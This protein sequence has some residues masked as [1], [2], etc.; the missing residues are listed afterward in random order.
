[1]GS[2][3]VYILGAVALVLAQTAL[4]VGLLLQ[5]ARRRHAEDMM[6]RS[7]AELR[8]SYDRIRDLGVRLMSAQEAERARI[9]RELHD[10]VSQQMALLAI[11]LG[12]LSGDSRMRQS[13]SSKLAHDAL[14][15]A[16]SVARSVHD[17]SHRLH[18]ANLRMLGLVEALVS[19][20]HEFA[21]SVR[22]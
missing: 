11:D 9:A 21:R 5:R 15:R 13:D 1:V 12:R 4:I 7:Q 20:Q 17:L 6:R 19:L 10:D 16:H 18:P 22:P 8:E 2:F 14:G 3:K